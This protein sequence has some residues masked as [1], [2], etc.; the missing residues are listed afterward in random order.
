MLKNWARNVNWSGIKS[1]HPEETSCF[2]VYGLGR[3]EIEYDIHQ[4]KNEKMHVTGPQRLLLHFTTATLR[5]RRRLA[6]N[7]W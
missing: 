3:D 2:R 1:I 7:I 4:L 5:T 6:E